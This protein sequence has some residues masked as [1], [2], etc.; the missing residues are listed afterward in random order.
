MKSLIVTILKALFG[1][2]GLEWIHALRFVYLIK[3]GKNR[4]PEMNIISLCLMKGEVAVD[5][6]ANGANWTYHLSKAVGLEGQV[7]AFEIDPYYA[8]VTKKTIKLLSLKNTIIFEYGLSDK[9]EQHYLN[10]CDSIGRRFRGLSHL[11][12][13]GDGIGSNKIMVILKKLDD[14][15]HVHPKLLETSLL[16]CDVEGYEMHVL[17]GAKKIIEKNNCIIILEIGHGHRYG[18]DVKDIFAFMYKRNYDGYILSDFSI[19]KNLFDEKCGQNIVFI[20]RKS[21]SRYK[22]IKIKL[23][24]ISVENLENCLNL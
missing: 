8:K 15:I 5:A 16:K 10:V 1:E 20:P 19:K 9:E 6:G 2:G 23:K 7:Y 22:L 14:L 12:Y 18:Y 11:A 24:K 4:E 17:R 3:K 13:S 21:E